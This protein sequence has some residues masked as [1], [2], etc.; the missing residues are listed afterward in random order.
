MPFPLV[1]IVF[2]TVST[3]LAGLGIKKGLDAKKVFE[4]AKSIGSTAEQK[5]REAVAEFNSG[6]RQVIERTESLGNKKL[7]YVT[8]TAQI[9]V[10]LIDNA[11]AKAEVSEW[12]LD[13]GLI[14]GIKEISRLKDSQGQ[15]KSLELIGNAGDAISSAALGAYGIYGAVSALATASTGTSIAQLSGAA[16]TKATLA[17]F[18]G[19]SLA[20]GGLGVAGGTWVLG[21]L[22]AGPALA[23][24]GFRLA[25][26][27]EEALTKAEEY[28]AEVEQ[29]LAEIKKAQ[30]IVDAL[31]ARIEEVERTL[32][33]L[34]DAFNRL[35]DQYF[36]IPEDTFN[37]EWTT[38][39]LSQEELYRALQ[40]LI[41]LYLAIKQVVEMPLLDNDGRPVEGIKERCRQIVEIVSASLKPEG[42]PT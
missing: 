19:G 21:G 7:E 26:K 23:I 29:K 20:T 3:I 31:E 40:K 12:V 4:K 14:E 30:V 35:K 39:T 8:Q 36:A 27:A 11:H 32:D 16:A 5:H 41:Q 18:G 24:V 33:W 1:P 38:K 10:K 17:W 22:V 13:D 34:M 28:A 9:L 2:G 42:E 15:I 25:S 37:A 6:L